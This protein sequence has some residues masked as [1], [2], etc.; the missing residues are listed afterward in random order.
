MNCTR[1]VWAVGL[2]IALV[3]VHEAS[4]QSSELIRACAGSDRPTD[5]RML[6]GIVTS[7]SG[8]AR[9]NAQVLM[10]W[11]VGPPEAGVNDRLQTVTDDAGRYAFCEV[12][13]V[14]RVVLRAVFGGQASEF[15]PVDLGTGAFGRVPDRGEW[16]A[17]LALAPAERRMV[18]MTGVVTD[19]S[20]TRPLAEA[21]VHLWGTVE[22]ARTD[23]AGRFHL[24]NV[25]AGQHRLVIRRIG[26]QPAAFDLVVPDGADAHLEPGQLAVRPASETLRP[27]VV[28]AELGFLEEFNRRRERTS[29]S[30]L[31]REDFE[32]YSPTQVTDILRHLPNISVR[33]NPHY[34]QE[35]DYRQFVV[36][37]RRALVR[38]GEPPSF[39][40]VLT[41]D[42][43]PLRTVLT[44]TA[45][46]PVI[47]FVNGVYMGT[48]RDVEIDFSIITEDIEAVES[49]FGGQIPAQFNR[50]GASCGVVA[51][52]TR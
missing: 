22:T 12:P 23:S 30:F 28:V 5:G 19:A 9:G 1:P 10:S 18:R 3:A 34:R 52:W 49:Y 17:D 2:G 14:H 46:C 36:E 27:I 39:E 6:G 7:L 13:A 45:E 32:K 21:T 15:V 35:G 24:S 8:E 4:A 48:S 43:N 38:A 40:R 16:S 11:P 50:L 25:W 29:G 20:T 44:E 31:T 33:A 26:F 37:G 41:H 42:A 47:F 51:F